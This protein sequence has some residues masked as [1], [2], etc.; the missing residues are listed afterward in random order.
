MVLNFIEG[1][2][3]GDGSGGS[4]DRGL[5]SSCGFITAMV[6][7]TLKRFGGRLRSLRLG[8]TIVSWFPN[9]FGTVGSL[10]SD[11]I[12]TNCGSGEATE[13]I[14]MASRASAPDSCVELATSGVLFRA[15]LSSSNEL[16]T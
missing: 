10:V 15:G 5:Y 16:S 7:N 3:I 13:E 11:S 4:G 14:V 12:S 1:V 2:D 6:A 9:P 8:G